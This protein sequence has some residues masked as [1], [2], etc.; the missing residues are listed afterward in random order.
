MSGLTIV[1]VS[2]VRRRIPT[3]ARKI[4]VE[5]LDDLDGTQPD[6]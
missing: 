4:L 2:S 3:M 6:G 1:L 5:M